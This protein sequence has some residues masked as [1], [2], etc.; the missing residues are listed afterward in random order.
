ML[1][2]ATAKGPSCR[3]CAMP[4]HCTRS[5]PT[6]LAGGIE[7]ILET[8][9]RVSARLAAEDPDVTLIGFAG[10]PFTVASYMVEGGGSKD[11]AATRLLASPGPIAV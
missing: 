9:R 10:A 7:P 4:L 6:R 1:S 5:I 11:F 8:V 3:R 2:I